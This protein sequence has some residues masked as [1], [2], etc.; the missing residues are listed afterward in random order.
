[1]QTYVIHTTQECTL[2]KVNLLM[3]YKLFFISIICGSAYSR[4]LSVPGFCK[5]QF[6][7]FFPL[8]GLNSEKTAVEEQ[9]GC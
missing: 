8:G 4:C 9:E 1:M 3:S 7:M 6:L 5:L 2:E